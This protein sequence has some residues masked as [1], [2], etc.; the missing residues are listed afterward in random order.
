MDIEL[1]NFKDV[2]T[3]YSG[4]KASVERLGRVSAMD[5]HR[6]RRLYDLLGEEPLPSI[7]KENFNPFQQ[8]VCTE[9]FLKDL[10]G[11]VKKWVAKAIE[12][13]WKKLKQLGRFIEDDFRRASELT[14]EIGG[15]ISKIDTAS[16][17][18]DVFKP[19]AVKIGFSWDAIRQEDM[20]GVSIKTL[21]HGISTV[22][23]TYKEA[24]NMNAYVDVDSFLKAVTDVTKL[25]K[26]SEPTR[27]KAKSFHAKFLNTSK[28][29]ENYSCAVGIIS[30]DSRLISLRSSGITFTAPISDA[31]KDSILALANE[32]RETSYTA[33]KAYTKVDEVLYKMSK[34]YEK[35][36]EKIA[37]GSV[38]IEEPAH[39]EYL[40]AIVED[41]QGFHEAF[42]KTPMYLLS[43]I[44][45]GIKSFVP[46]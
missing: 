42:I 35:L 5:L 21:R 6:A 37:K 33:T 23:E 34:Q 1:N 17:D 15:Y 20:D 29:V 25:G 41:G 36:A 40:K 22:R 26:L 45:D 2:V 43:D 32:V 24:L 9:S 28:G 4:I 8:E 14:K 30:R 12:W 7:A 13:I 11:K 10:G 31:S 3:E 19:G 27:Q 44:A 16:E 39:V 46:K 38:T 18:A